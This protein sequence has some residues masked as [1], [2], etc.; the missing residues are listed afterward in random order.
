MSPF[1]PL[2]H[3]RLQ[4]DVADYRDVDPIF[5]TLDDFDRLVAEAHACGIRVVIDLVPNHT[6]DR[7]P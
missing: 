6:S 3:G 7:H 4:G 1:C 2:A 5:G